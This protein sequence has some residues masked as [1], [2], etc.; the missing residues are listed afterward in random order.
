MLTSKKMLRVVSSAF[1]YQNYCVIRLYI[2]KV[3]RNN[4]RTS[5]RYKAIYE[6]ISEVFEDK[7]PADGIINDYMRSR[8][9]IGS[10]DRRFISDNVWSIIRNRRKLEFDAKSSNIRDI[11]H[12]Y[13]KDK[14]LD[15]VFDGSEYGLEQLTAKEKARTFDNDEVYPEDVELETPKWLFDKVEDKRLLKALNN[16]ATADF[17]INVKNRDALIED[18]SQEGLEFYKTPYSPI[19]IRSDE[20]INLANCIAFREGKFDVQ[21][22]G[23]QIISSLCK[24]KPGHKILDYC[25]GAGGKSLTL[26]YLLQGKGKI[27][28]HDINWH[29]L[30]QI[31]PRMERLGVDNIELI[32]EVAYNDYDCFIIDAPCSGTGTWRRSPDAKYRLTPTRLAELTKTQMQILNY[33]YDHTKVGGKIIYITCSILIDE[34]EDVVVDFLN[35]HDGVRLLKIN[36]SWGECFNLPYPNDDESF[37][38]LAPH[39]T[40][41]DGFFMAIF[42]KIS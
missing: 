12:I 26:S 18:L 1:I 3:G 13:A 6:I 23:S 14:D 29:R 24:V 4:M 7:K 10:K 42:E 32:R 5:A 21:D 28:A 19:G 35:E 2:V 16:P 33:A 25:A 11:L 34:N 8:R 20:R 31:K 36:G 37:L 15:E 27:Y 40:N 38:R 17:R 39:T 41:T 30:E 22:E 9:Y